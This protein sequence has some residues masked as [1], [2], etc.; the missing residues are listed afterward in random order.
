MFQG[1]GRILE[2]RVEIRQGKMSGVACLSEEAE[3]GEAKFLD[4]VD[5]LLMMA[6]IYL[7]SVKGMGGQTSQKKGLDEDV[8]KE[9]A[10]LS[11][12]S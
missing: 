3:I 2:G 8:N 11:H 6:H 7:L 9:K 1:H 4:Q 5:L 10:G 12:G